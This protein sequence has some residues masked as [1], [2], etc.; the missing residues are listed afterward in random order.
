M[1]RPWLLFTA[2]T[3]ALAAGAALPPDPD[4]RTQLAAHQD[5]Q[6]PL[7][8]MVLRF[9][10][11]DFKAASRLSWGDDDAGAIASKDG[12]NLVRWHFRGT[13][14]GDQHK[15]LIQIEGGKISEI[16]LGEQLPDGSVLTAVSHS[17]IETQHDGCTTT[18][19]LYRGSASQ[20]PS[21]NECADP[22]SN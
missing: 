19:E 11:T 15:A 3:A 12:P 8:T 9:E 4:A 22:E 17:A 20:S 6:L 16:A 1:K 18:R 2:L 5:W 14:E 21:L 13:A 7:A 10:N